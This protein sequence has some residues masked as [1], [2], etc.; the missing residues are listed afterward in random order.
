VLGENGDSCNPGPGSITPDGDGVV[1][2]ILWS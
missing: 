2:R 1:V